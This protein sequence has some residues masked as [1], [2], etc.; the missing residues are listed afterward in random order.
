MDA[1]LA[2]REEEIGLCFKASPLQKAWDP[3]WKINW[4]GKTGCVSQAVEASVRPWVQTARKKSN[5]L[6]YT[7]T[8]TN[9]DFLPPSPT[10]FVALSFTDLSEKVKLILKLFTK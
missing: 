3:I 6:L 2:R 10:D 5:L 8:Y 4:S 7:F 9:T 1:I